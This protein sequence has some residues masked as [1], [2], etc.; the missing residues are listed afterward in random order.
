MEKEHLNLVVIGHIDHGKSTFV[1]R[2]LL[3]TG[4]ISSHQIEKYREQ[5]REMGKSTFEFAWVMDNLKEERERG[6]TIDLNHKKFST[7]KREYT[8]IDAP[9]HRDFIKNMIT[10]TAQADF[11]VLVV[12]IK[13]GIMT[14]TEEHA[15][16]SRTLGLSNLVVAVNKMDTVNYS[17]EKFNAFA[18]E[19][20]AFLKKIGY[21]TFSIIP[22]S[23][24]EGENIS[25][26]SKKM[27]WYK[28]N[29]I[30]SQFDLIEHTFVVSKERKDIKIPIEDICSITGIGTVPIG[31]IESGTLYPGMMVQFLPSNKKGEVKSIQMH[32]ENYP[33]ASPG[34]N[35]GFNVKGIGRTDLKR[36]EVL[37]SVENKDVFVPS[38]FLAKIVVYDHPS[39]IS[40][41]Y[42]PVVHCHT[43]QVACRFKKLI[44]K[45][46][47]YTGKVAEENPSFLK[48]GDMAEVELE[49]ISPLMIESIS[50]SKKLSRFAIRD[51]G[52]TI[53]AGICTKV[54]P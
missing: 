41:G 5:A 54:L 16:L 21:K 20:T 38:S 46:N 8:I 45:I 49:P 22:V 10:G 24:F 30:L 28:G 34:M 52:K 32:H 44:S 1:G 14:Q 37:Y 19:I 4:V 39:I 11:G 6:I 42:I 13:E 36:G 2:L 51:M 40:E 53:A 7:K 43:A 18:L 48:K 50:T 23:A 3:E 26:R 9:G 35:I 27:G 12:S 15:F 25:Q 33:M 47:L 31:K 29:S 17:E